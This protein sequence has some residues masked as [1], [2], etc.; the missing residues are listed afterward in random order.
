MK[1][2]I[3]NGN[4]DKLEKELER[5]LIVMRYSKVATNVYIRIFGWVEDYLDGYG[6]T[7][8]SKELGQRFLTEYRLQSIHS[9]SQF[10]NART[11]I[12]RMDEILENKLFTPCFRKSKSECP[13]RFTGSRDKYL[14]SLA[15]RG[16]RI[17]TIN[18]QKMYTGRFLARL[19]E[20]VL[21]LEELAAADLYDIL[22]KYEWPSVGLGTARGFLS[23]LFE[24]GVTKINLS[25]CVPRPRR[26]HPLP[27]VYSGAEVKRLLSSVDRTGSKG[28]RDYAILILAAYLGLRSSDI[29]NLSF[30]DIDR[31]AKTI[32]II[33]TKT[34]RP[35]T[36]VMNNETEEAITDYIRDGRPQSSSGRI[37]LSS[38][39]PF[40]PLTAGAGYAVALKY[41]N[42]SGIQAQGRRRG[43]HALRASYATA[44][45]A[46][47]VP[48][49]AVQKALGHE[50]QE[51]AKYYVRLDVRRLRMC[52]LDVPKPIGAFALMLEPKVRAD[53]EGALS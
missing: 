3:V 27:S 44:L 28:K 24:N 10:K 9:P 5:R 7:D 36:L 41:F 23:F 48:Y 31:A 47:G 46:K 2:K 40:E 34:S 53:L 42:L 29:V 51:S 32:R 17:T 12:R 26:P 18:S 8:Y 37:F 19:P 25:N 20:T 4:L 6:E 21:S 1:Q 16:Y 13:S 49:A 33:Q 15:K 38:Q 50:D 22:T 45:V 39:A 43:T 52:A 35:L 30:G 14:E 11:V